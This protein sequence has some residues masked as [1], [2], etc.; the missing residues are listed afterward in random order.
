MVRPVETV[1]MKQVKNVR[2]LAAVVVAAI[3]GAFGC[4][5]DDDLL[6]RVTAKV[7]VIGVDDD[8]VVALDIGDLP[9]LRSQ[10]PN[11]GVVEMAL[12]LPPGTYTGSIATVRITN[13]DGDGDDPD[14]DGDDV[15]VR[16]GTFD[17]TVVE[18][19]VAVKG[20][21]VDDLPRCGPDDDDGDG[22]GDDDGNG[23]DDGGECD[24]DVGDG[25]EGEGDA[26]HGHDGGDDD[27]GEGEG[28]DPDDNPDDNPDDDSGG[29]GEGEGDV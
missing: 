4:L 17:L 5:T 25:E 13:D 9:P 11:D 12:I 23:D 15:P 22:D 21:I 29:G 1:T 18:G 24:D 26:D 6:K 19:D 16:C 27:L 14:N 3:F 8:E 2:L 7:L 20:I 10:A 28:D